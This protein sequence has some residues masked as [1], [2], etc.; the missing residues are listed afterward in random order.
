MIDNKISKVY[1]ARVRGNF[2]KCKNIEKNEVTVKNLIYC[3]SN[4]DAFWGCSE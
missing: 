2:S 4:I 1:Y 3:I